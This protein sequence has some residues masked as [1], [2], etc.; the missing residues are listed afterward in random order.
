MSF[1]RADP[2][3]FDIIFVANATAAIKLV[4]ELFRDQE[5]GF[6]YGYHG[7]METL[8]QVSSVFVNLLETLDAL[9][10]ML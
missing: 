5:S 8:I 3:H 6:W 2:K 1:F 7:F 4:A 10:E 9:V